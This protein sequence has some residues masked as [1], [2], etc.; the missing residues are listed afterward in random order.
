MNSPVFEFSYSR[1]NI[2]I[3]PV[4]NPQCQENTWWKVQ[5]LSKIY[6]FK[7]IYMSIF[8]IFT[9]LAH[10][11][12]QFLMIF[13]ET[14]IFYAQFYV[15]LSTANRNFPPSPLFQTLLASARFVKLNRPMCKST[16]PSNWWC[17]SLPRAPILSD[18]LLG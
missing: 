2:I 3:H 5:N 7:D 17:F 12:H 6:K 13:E 9:Y 15:T 14:I 8:T 16:I 18:H 1:I 11:L 10:L 4:L